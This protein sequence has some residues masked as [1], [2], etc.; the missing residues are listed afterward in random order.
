MDFDAGVIR[1]PRGPDPTARTDRSPG[2]SERSSRR[3][4]PPSAPA[5]TKTLMAPASGVNP[6]PGTPHAVG[7]RRMVERPG[8]VPVSQGGDYGAFYVGSRGRSPLRGRGRT[9]DLA[10]EAHR[11]VP[12]SPQGGRDSSWVIALPEAHAREPGTRAR[13]AGPCRRRAD[14]RPADN[15][16][17]AHLLPKSDAEAAAKVAALVTG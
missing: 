1:V 10:I 4:L 15:A 17:D 16:T 12:A 5:G 2:R 6:C 11:G 14:R 9:T 7:Q 8:P 3:R 13:R